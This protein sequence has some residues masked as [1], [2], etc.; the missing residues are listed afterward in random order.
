VATSPVIVESATADQR[1]HLWPIGASATAS[2]GRAVVEGGI[3]KYRIVGVPTV[4]DIEPAEL[5]ECDPDDPHTG[6]FRPSNHVGT[7]NVVV[8][9]VD[10]TER[11]FPIEVRP[12]KLDDDSQYRAMLEQI[13]DRAAEA[14]LQGF[15]PATAQ[16]HIDAAATGELRYRAL[17]FLVAR[18]RD[19]SFQAALEQIVRAPHRRWTATTEHRHISRGLSPGSA[20]ARQFTRPG[21]RVDRPGHLG[22]LPPV[23]LPQHTE[24]QRNVVTYDTPPNRFVRHAFESWRALAQDV[25]TAFDG[26]DA[27]GA[28]PRRRGLREARWLEQRCTQMLSSPVLAEASPMRSLPMG[29]PVLLRQAGYRDVLRVYALAQASIALDAELPDDAFSA[30][31]RNIATLYEY[32]CFLV[33]LDT[34]EGLAGSPSDA[35]VFEPSSSGMSLVLRHGSQHRH[36]WT[37]EVNG[38]RLGLDLWFN[39]NFPRLDSATADASSWASSMRPDVSL[40]IRPQSAR[41]EGAADLDLDVWLHFDAKYRVQRQDVEFSDDPVTTATRSDVLKMHSYRDAIR[42]SAGAY[43]LYPGDGPRLHREEFHELLPGIGAFPLR[44][45]DHGSVSGVEVLEAFLHDVLRQAANQ[46]SAAERTQFWMAKHTRRPGR[47]VRPANI[48]RT[49]PA[50]ELVLVGYVRGEQW[51]WVRATRRYN[52]R[53]DSRP[54]AVAVADD[55]LTARLLVLWTGHVDEPELLGLF[56]RTGPWQV[57]SAGDLAATSYPVR[58]P[59]AS[60]LVTEINAAAAA[61]EQSFDM[62]RLRHQLPTDYRPLALTWEHLAAT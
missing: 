38:R 16:M 40:R 34:I 13:A 7:I 29:D 36:S 25:I 26:R 33:L 35:A 57:A 48:L 23:G 11:G 20:A 22:H 8:T 45:G 51:S 54:G 55:M 49:P 4:L 2:S 19:E 24:W 60:Y 17:A 44:P 59:S 61:L 58:E 5:F 53:A 30:T 62:A 3:Y 21:R 46:A 41:P 39:R 56:E 43:V 42:R 32:W 1:L 27:P 52:V 9:S 47:R 15:A 18:L 10:G 37:V 14:L 6:R 50:D 31:Q 28:G 12:A